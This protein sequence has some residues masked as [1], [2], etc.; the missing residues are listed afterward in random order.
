MIFTVDFFSLVNTQ[1]NYHIFDLTLFLCN[2]QIKTNN[3]VT[4]FCCW[5]ST[6]QLIRR[7]SKSTE[8]MILFHKFFGRE[9]C[10]IGE[11]WWNKVLSIQ[12]C[13]RKLFIISYQ[14]YIW[15]LDKWKIDVKKDWSK[16]IIPCFYYWS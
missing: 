8:T 9:M 14:L 12:I 7:K 15:T 2:E 13:Y 3:N 10:V 16:Q 11:R 1:H 6:N 4:W 5:W